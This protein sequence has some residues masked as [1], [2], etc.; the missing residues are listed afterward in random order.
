MIEQKNFLSVTQEYINMRGN[1]IT[2]D[3]TG[4]SRVIYI[5][6]GCIVMDMYKYRIK[7]KLTQPE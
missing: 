5:F 1:I 2:H 4:S 6:C 3:W 7:D